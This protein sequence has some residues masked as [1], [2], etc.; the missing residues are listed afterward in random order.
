MEDDET[1]EDD[2]TRS[3]EDEFLDDV[4]RA[5]TDERV[6]EDDVTRFGC[7]PIELM[8][9]SEQ[10]DVVDDA[11]LRDRLSGLSDGRRGNLEVVLLN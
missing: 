6:P 2:V 11:A 3:D 10:S 7:F 5:V 9:S 8:V 1:R 4:N